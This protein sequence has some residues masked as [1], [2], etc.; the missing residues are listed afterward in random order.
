LPADTTIASSQGTQPSKMNGGDEHR[1]MYCFSN[2]TSYFTFYGLFYS[3][4]ITL[5][6]M[7][8]ANSTTHAQEDKQN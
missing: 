2:T 4:R 1:V 3:F 7:W 8:L 5:W 6:P